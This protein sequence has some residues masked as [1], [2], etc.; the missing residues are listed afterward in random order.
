M[1]KP[2]W[3]AHDGQ[4]VFSIHVHPDG[5]RFATAGND[6]KAKIWALLPCVDEAA[7]NNPAVARTLATLSGHEGSVNCV[8]WS[9]NGRLLAS[10]S[11]DHLVMLW[12]LAAPG[13]RLGAMP[14]GSGAAPN[15]ERW[16]CVATLRGHSG[17]VVDVAWAPDACRL[18]S[19]SLDNSVRIWEGS[20]D[21]DAFSVLKVLEGH[22][23]MVKGVA[24]DPIGRYVA[25]QG[26]DRAAIVWDAREW[27]QAAKIESPFQRTS[28][29]T[30]FRRL[31]WAPDGQHLCCPHAFKKPVNV[32]VALCR[33][34]SGTA[35]VEACDFVGHTDPVVC[36]G[37]NPRT[38]R[39]RAAAPS[40]DGAGAAAGG[41]EAGA[42]R[43]YS[44][45]ALGGQDC[46]LSIWLTTLPRPLLVVRQIFEQDVLDLSWTPDGRTLLACSM[47]GTVACVHLDEAEIGT[48]VRV[49]HATSP[50]ATTS[51]THRALAPCSPRA[52]TSLRPIFANLRKSQVPHEEQ[53]SQLHKLYGDYLHTNPS[54]MVVES[55]AMLALEKQRAAA[56]AASSLA[57]GGPMGTAGAG[58]ASVARLPAPTAADAPPPAEPSA[59]EVIALQKETRQRDGRRRI[60]PVAI[61]HVAAPGACTCVSSSV[62]SMPLSTAAGSAPPAANSAANSAAGGG[63]NPAFAPANSAFAA[64]N[65]PNALSSS[66]ARAPAAVTLTSPASGSAMHPLGKRPPQRVEPQLTHTLPGFGTAVGGEPRAFPSGGAAVGAPAKK[67]RVTLAPSRQPSSDTT[68]GPGASTHE[69]GHAAGPSMVPN[70]APHMPLPPA[71]VPAGPIALEL[72]EAEAA[73]EEEWNAAGGGAA[74]VT[75][76][77][78]GFA[79]SAPRIL[80]AAPTGSGVSAGAITGRGLPS[81]SASLGAASVLTCSWQGEVLWTAALA[82]PVTLLAGNTSFAAAACADGS[83]CVFTPAGRRACPPLMPCAGGVAALA[84]DS[85]HRLLVVGADGEVVIFAHLPQQPHCVLRCSAAPLLRRPAT[86]AADGAGDDASELN[87][88]GGYGGDAPMRLLDASIIKGGSPLLL[89]PHGA[90]TYAEGLQSWLAMG[91]EVFT[92]SEHRSSLPPTLPDGSLPPS[93]PLP[94][95]RWQ[96]GRGP[97]SLAGLQAHHSHASGRHDSANPARLASAMA[98]AP[99]EHQRLVSL[100]HLEHQMAASRALGNADE[101]RQWLRA[102]ATTLGQHMAVR[103]VRELCDELLGPIDAPSAGSAAADA[104]SG[105]TPAPSMRWSPRVLGLCK[106]TLLREVVLPALATNR[107][108]QRIL[109]EYVENLAAVA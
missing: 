86:H 95:R 109:S 22:M 25:S 6:N 56:A 45:V 13:E 54:H 68:R 102:Y 19:V 67:A 32:A 55:P 81:A 65:S 3:V 14:F 77:A 20:A 57:G 90:F 78:V 89:L 7:E 39:R 84:A 41:G 37:F 96:P 100:A 34:T 29:K 21:G 72:P 47:D 17:D 58:H 61:D 74:E 1:S 24:W 11:D 35:W 2:E 43:M 26:D 83:V 33:P 105:E 76:G 101:Y 106:R 70:H 108:L 103:P 27:R 97:P 9:P 59:E 99:M 10:G 44:C 92:L 23:G 40:A 62:S 16:R 104:P 79:G 82:K 18:A 91:D 94:S 5:T 15:V 98:A 31:G 75:F 71:C 49:A 73:D 63:A 80:E 52:D 107:A 51:A 28:Q 69:T 48:P 42:G 38:F 4:P 85:S 66:I 53:R 88:H 36:A 60:M 50:A 87:G 46:T 12:R 64:A 8:R 30:L 93:L